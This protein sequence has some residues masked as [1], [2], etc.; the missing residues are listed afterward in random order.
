MRI[1]LYDELPS[2]CFVLR[3]SLSSN[4]NGLGQ[5]LP[6]Q[7]AWVACFLTVIEIVEI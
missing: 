5:S 1:R 7:K 3:A 2:P 6:S 4:G